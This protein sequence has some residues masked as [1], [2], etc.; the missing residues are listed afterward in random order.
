MDRDYAVND[1]PVSIRLSELPQLLEPGRAYPLQL[2]VQHPALKRAGFQI[3]ARFEDGSQA[4]SWLVPDTSILRV[5][6]SG[7]V[8][9]LSHT[10]QGTLQVHGDTAAWEFHW[11]APPANRPV[12]FSVAVNVSNY[13]AS[14]FGDRIFTQSF[15]AGGERVRK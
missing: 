1:G 15:F 14:E 7:D 6:R 4:G 12:T 13:D 5:Q 11:Q 3:T 10:E 8:A 2:R 9:Y